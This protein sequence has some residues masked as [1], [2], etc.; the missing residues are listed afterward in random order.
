[1]W[2]GS[3]IFFSYLMSETCMKHM[4]VYG[5]CIN[6]NFNVTHTKSAVEYKLVRSSQPQPHTCV[7]AET[8]GWC[9]TNVINILQ[10]FAILCNIHRTSDSY[11]IL[12]PSTEQFGHF[13]PIRHPLP[14]PTQ[15]SQQI[16]A[17][18]YR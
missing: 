7:R 1:M 3:N 18:N 11:D 13:F 15:Q 2:L 14:R 10:Y 5:I 4:L 9:V 8:G 17:I 12:V 6:M 16:S